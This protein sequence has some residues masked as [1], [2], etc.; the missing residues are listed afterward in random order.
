MGPLQCHQQIMSRQR[1]PVV[2]ELSERAMLVV[3]RRYHLPL[4]IA[5]DY[6]AVKLINAV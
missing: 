5:I 2:H 3:L 4:H 6:I 1:Q